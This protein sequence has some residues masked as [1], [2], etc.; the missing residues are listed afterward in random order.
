MQS[1][2]SN[3]VECIEGHNAG[4]PVKVVFLPHIPGKTMLEKKEYCASNLDHIRK[5]LTY[6]P[7]SGSNS[8]G[9]VVTSPS[10]K[11]AHFGAI[12][13]D[14]SGWHDM[15]GHATMFLASMSVQRNLI[16]IDGKKSV[17]VFIDTPA[18]RV[19]VTVHLK[20]N[21]EV[22]HVSLTNVPSFVHSAFTIKL[23]NFGEINIPVVFGGDFYAM[24]D[25]D[26]FNISY[27]REALP[28]IHDISTEILSKLKDKELTHPIEKDLKGIYGVRY[29][30]TLSQEPRRMYG[31]LF[32]GTPSR[33]SLDRSP[34]GTSSSAHL[35]Y[36]YYIRKQLKLGE[37]VEFLSSIGTKFIGVAK[38]ETQVGNYKA[39]VPEISTVDKACFITGFSTYVVDE[40]DPL[41]E[42]YKP[43][44]PF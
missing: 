9:V 4:M 15:C 44:E 7:R 1:A 20:E 36:L 2:F 21:G 42:G 38:E 30:S 10:Q 28:E 5:L 8:Y 32:F 39:I 3:S 25:L 31:V 43:V 16:M 24:V 13:F 12:Y 18:G 11:D 34:S 6:E 41:E 35:A 17:E 40:L 33:V 27:S 14:P 29:Q 26:A 22:D 37:K 23:K 19:S